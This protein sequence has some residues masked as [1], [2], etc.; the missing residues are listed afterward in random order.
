[1]IYCSVVQLEKTTLPLALSGR[2]TNCRFKQ[3]CNVTI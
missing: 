2:H 1:M 3:L